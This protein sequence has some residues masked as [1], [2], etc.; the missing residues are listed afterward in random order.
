MRLKNPF[1]LKKNICENEFLFHDL[2]HCGTA[3]RKSNLSFYARQTLVNILRNEEVSMVLCKRTYRIRMMMLMR[4]M[5][6]MGRRVQSPCE[7]NI[8]TYRRNDRTKRVVRII[9]ICI[10]YLQIHKQAHQCVMTV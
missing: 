1:F 4:M 3:M 9:K 7:N 2:T 5:T 8:Y 6:M 10:L